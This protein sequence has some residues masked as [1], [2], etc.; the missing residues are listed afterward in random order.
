[1][2]SSKQIKI[3]KARASKILRSKTARALAV[4]VT[5]ALSLLLTA[6]ETNREIVAELGKAQLRETQARTQTK[7]EK[8]AQAQARAQAQAKAK[9]QAKTQAKTDK[10][11][12]VQARAQAQ[13]QAKTQKEAQKIAQK[14]ALKMAQAN[15]PTKAQLKA[16][17]RAQEEFAPPSTNQVLGHISWVD[18]N[19]PNAVVYLNNAQLHPVDTLLARDRDGNPHALLH[20]TLY[21]KERALGVTLPYGKPSVGDEVILRESAVLPDEWEKDNFTIANPHKQHFPFFIPDNIKL[22]ERKITPEE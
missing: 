1:M 8:K 20:P 21:H 12:Q 17:V 7:A 22:P 2:V 19:G 11:A 5:A 16:Q 14:M 6:C 15:A 4:S 3:Q 13:N 18:S 10:K 9:A